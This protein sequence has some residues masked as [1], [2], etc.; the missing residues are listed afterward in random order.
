MLSRGCCQ[1]ANPGVT[2]AEDAALKVRLSNLSVSDDREG[3]RI[4]KVFFRW[5]DGETEK[6]YPFITIDLVDIDFQSAIRERQESERNYYYRGEATDS[7]VYYPSELDGTGLATAL[8]DSGSPYLRIDQNVPVNLIY[9]VTT[10][11]RSQRHDR[12]LAMLMLR[13]VFP[14]R[15]GFIDIPEDGTIRRC[16]LLDF[17]VADVLDKEVG[18]KK[19]IFR[20]VYTLS[21]NAEFA[22]SDLDQLEQ[23]LTV[24]GTI[25]GYNTAPIPLTTDFT[26]EF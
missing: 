14:L 4:P 19:R 24:N 12:Q 2:L 6:L 17:Q 3:V 16:T 25:E 7:L 23:V 5:P 11:C 18:Y 15:R 13:R 21:I 8:A 26:E 1:L 10:N 9:Q 22:Q 20:N